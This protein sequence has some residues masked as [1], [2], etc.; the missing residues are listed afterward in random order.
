MEWTDDAIVIGARRHGESSVI[1]EAMTASRGR[2]LGLV[3]G[4]RSAKLQPVLQAGNG[5]R[6]VWRARLEDHLG[7]FSVEGLTLRET[8]PVIEKNGAAIA[9]VKGAITVPAMKVLGPSRTFAAPILGSV[10][11]A[12]AEQVKDSKGTLEA[13]DSVGTNGLQFRYDAQLRGT[14]GLAVQAVKRGADGSWHLGG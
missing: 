5:V 3:R 9:K 8:D 4:G 7:N 13:G 11:E 2:H 6:L 14:P 10:G 1:L 12:T